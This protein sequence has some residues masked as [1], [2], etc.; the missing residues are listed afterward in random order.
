LIDSS[1]TT[2]MATARR[3]RPPAYAAENVDRP[4]IEALRERGFDVLAADRV[5][6]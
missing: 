3:N 1:G 2:P 4:L 5:G 6:S